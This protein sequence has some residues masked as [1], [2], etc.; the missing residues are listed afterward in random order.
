MNDDGDLS[1]ERL[2]TVT[3]VENEAVSRY[4]VDSS[5]AAVAMDKTDMNNKRLQN[6]KD[7]RLLSDS[8]A[9]RYTDNADGRFK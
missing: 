1:I 9:K 7:P 6:L 8:S 2:K 4:Y 5:I 3:Y